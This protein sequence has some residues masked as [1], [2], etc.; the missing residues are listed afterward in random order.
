M[1]QKSNFWTFA[2]RISTGLFFKLINKLITLRMLLEVFQLLF[3]NSGVFTLLE[4]RAIIVSNILYFVYLIY[5][6]GTC[7]PIPKV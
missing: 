4:C 6:N 2:F 3:L 5:H 1:L 7:I